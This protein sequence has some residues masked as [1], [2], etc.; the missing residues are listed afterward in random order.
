ME[1]GS[2]RKGKCMKKVGNRS[3]RTYRFGGLVVKVRENFRS[4]LKFLT[5]VIGLMVVVLVPKLGNAKS[6]R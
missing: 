5:K 4:T 3:S 1:V 6:M 2:K